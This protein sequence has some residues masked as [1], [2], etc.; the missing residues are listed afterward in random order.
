MASPCVR[1]GIVGASSAAGSEHVMAAEC[2]EDMSN[3]KT[4]RMHLADG[5]H[6]AF[7]EH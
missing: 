2:E 6:C 3:E 7:D 5:D 1:L 4:E